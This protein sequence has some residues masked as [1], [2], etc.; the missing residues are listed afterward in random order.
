MHYAASQKAGQ[1]VLFMLCFLSKVIF[2]MVRVA[3]ESILITG[4]K[5]GELYSLS[6]THVAF[7]LV[8]WFPCLPKNVS[9]IDWLS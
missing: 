6:H 8:V 5:V 7:L 1:D 2:I 9:K 4:H 3:V